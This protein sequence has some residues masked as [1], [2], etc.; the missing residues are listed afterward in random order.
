MLRSWT[1]KSD[2]NIEVKKNTS[3]FNSIIQC[4]KFILQSHVNNVY[5]KTASSK[6]GHIDKMSAFSPAS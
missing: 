5:I 3:H 4:F 1:L 2:F 6:I